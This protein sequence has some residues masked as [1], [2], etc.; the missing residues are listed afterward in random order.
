MVLAAAS[1][2]AGG[3]K[4]ACEGLSPQVEVTLL[5]AQQLSGK[6]VA[7]L[8]ARAR[9]NGGA[10]RNYKLSLAQGGFD[11]KGG[12]FTI[13]F[14]DDQLTAGRRLGLEVRA[15]DSK[16]KALALWT[17]ADAVFEPNGCNFWELSPSQAA[18][19]G[20]G[21]MPVSDT[22]G[23][24]KD[25]GGAAPVITL[26]DTK[27]T[28]HLEVMG[29]A[30][31]DK[32]GAM[33]MCNVNGD[34]WDDLVVA[35]PKADGISAGLGAPHGRVYVIYGQNLGTKKLADLKS[36]DYFDI[37]LYGAG[38]TDH[39]GETL[40]CGD[41][42]GNQ[43]DDL[44]IGAPRADSNRGK[45]YVMLGGSSLDTSVDLATEKLPL[46]ITGYAKEDRFGAG[47][48]ILAFGGKGK[49]FIAVGAP[50]HDGAAST[51]D[52][53]PKDAG[54]KADAKVS[55]WPLASR[56]EAGAVFLIPGSYAKQ[57]KSASQALAGVSGLISM[58]GGMPD[59]KLGTQLAAGQMDQ[60]GMEDLA[61]AGAGL[62]DKGHSAY[63]AVRLLRGRDLGGKGAVIDC[64]DKAAN[65]HSR[66]LFGELTSARFGE[67][68][69]M[70]D[71]DADTFADVLVGAP[72]ASKAYLFLGGANS[73]P[74]ISGPPDE[75][76]VASTQYRA[77]FSGI[78]GSSFG[79]AL[80]AVPRD[81][82]I[83]PAADILVGA[84]DSDGTRGRFY[85][86]RRNK[87]FGT[88]EPVDMTKSKEVRLRVL[89]AGVGHRLGSAVAGGMYDI[90]D[91][92]PDV[93]GLAPGA[94]G[95]SRAEAGKA[96]LFVGTK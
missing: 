20:V 42:D 9:L 62:L 10:W 2:L 47:L 18:D 24:K 33:V 59:E 81:R 50:G 16:G 54:V 28:A 32:L 69:A 40:A 86:F 61:A 21:D 92:M 7:G 48:A 68:V 87:S 53:G 14:K 5:P 85:W 39:L 12:R 6:T 71:F 34:D 45:V 4:D 30:T 67:A 77:V 1:L 93:A 96:Y 35:A 78:K 51:G 38:K 19:G 64:Q 82:S 13:R 55:T 31:K 89:G 70:G 57:G 8:T 75:K 36:T 15:V 27:L 37:A 46:E 80:A 88:K 49:T 66:S 22:G 94:G 73:L 56:K 17:R 11:G 29:G 76:R 44:L 72:G 95:I 26:S 41:I 74:P 90:G 63:G 52:G 60:D 65:G 58:Q 79:H 84:P 83:K 91:S 43:Y 25:T 3:C 23:Q